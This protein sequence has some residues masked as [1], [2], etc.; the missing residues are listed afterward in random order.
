M[1][2]KTIHHQREHPKQEILETE[3]VHIFEKSEKICLKQLAGEV[4]ELYGIQ[5]KDL[6]ILLSRVN[7]LK[8]DGN[9]EEKVIHKTGTHVTL[10]L[11]NAFIPASKHHLLMQISHVLGKNM[12]R[13]LPT[14]FCIAKIFEETDIVIINIGA[15]QTSTTLKQHNE[16]QALSKISIGINDLV[17]KIARKNDLPRAEIIDA[18]ADSKFIAEKNEFLQI[19]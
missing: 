7:T 5:N 10:S 18:L 9:L 13:I 14:E 15:T 16:V 8:L 3:L 17:Q 11:L 19:W 2:S 4:D 1:A 12:Y 6:Q